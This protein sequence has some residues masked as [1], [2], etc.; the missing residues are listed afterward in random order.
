MCSS[1]VGYYGNVIQSTF[2]TSAERW[3]GIDNRGAIVDLKY[4][5]FVQNIGISARGSDPVYFV[6]P[7]KKVIYQ[8]SLYTMCIKNV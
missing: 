7:G 6:A 5:A 4:D 2:D 1:A 3:T 8:G